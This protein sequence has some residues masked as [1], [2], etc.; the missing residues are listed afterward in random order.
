MSLVVSLQC[1][2]PYESGRCSFP[3][4][5]FDEFDQTRQIIRRSP[6]SAFRSNAIDLGPFFSQAFPAT[7]TPYRQSRKA[8]GS[9]VR[10]SG[11]NPLHFIS[12]GSHAVEI[13]NGVGDVSSVV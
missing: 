11:N 1:P 13:C 3:I 2:L 12:G 10:V 6:L 7:A 8:H 4:N 5:C 9:E